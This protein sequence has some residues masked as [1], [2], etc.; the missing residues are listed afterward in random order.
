MNNGTVNNGTGRAA[1]T[2]DDVARVAGV[3]RATVSRVVNGGHLVSSAT[4][5]A[6]GRAISELGYHPNRVARAL[7][8]RRAGAVAVV[9][10]ET[11][12]RVFTDPFL[13]QA[14]HG[15]LNAF[16]GVD[17]QVL[18]AM[19]QPGESSLRM[20][21]YLESG[22]VDGAIVV[23]HH[24]PDLARA[25]LDGGCPAVF[26]GDPG[27]A[28]LPYVE[29]DQFNAAVAATRHLVEAGATRIATITGPLDM[30]AATERLRGF[31]AALA[32]A[33]LEPVGQLAGDF[34]ARGGER[35]MAALLDQRTGMDGLFVASDLMALGAMQAL[36]RARV[37]VPDDVRV[38]GF[39]NSP[40][41]L[42]THPLLTTMTN[43]AIELARIAGGMLL[44][45]FSGADI[46]SPVL[47]TSELIV[48][49]SA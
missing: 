23:S 9:V 27:V 6:V 20:A 16:A 37:R 12:E 30:N 24:G 19:A 22:H 49:G 41:A 21:R 42:Q 38:I 40:A 39:D 43:P 11:D 18:L 32:E 8:T 36:R 4:S 26:V 28:G 14:Y 48:R 25:L 1:P 15:A 10:P 35:A 2:L 33:G 47:L 29:L 46:E 34:T 31:T 3:S 5:E 17:F 45:L 13:T 44:G 7:A